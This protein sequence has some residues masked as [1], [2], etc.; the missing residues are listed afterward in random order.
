L[1][2]IHGQ[3]VQSGSFE[4]R[5]FTTTRPVTVYF[6]IGLNEQMSTNSRYPEFIIKF[7]AH[8]NE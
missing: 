3:V 2:A 6:Q 4:G 7:D 5:S 8:E 1:T